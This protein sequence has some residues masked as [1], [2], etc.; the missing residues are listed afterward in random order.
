MLQGFKKEQN[1]EV[2]VEGVTVD[3]LIRG[4][5]GVWYTTGYR[6]KGE[7]VCPSHNIPWVREVLGWRKQEGHKTVRLFGDNVLPFPKIKPI[8]V[9]GTPVEEL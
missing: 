8:G 3:T 1:P 9:L 5:G 6:K 7:W 2:P 4:E